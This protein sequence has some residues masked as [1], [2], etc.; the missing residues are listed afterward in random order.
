MG[1]PKYNTPAWCGK[2]DQNQRG[3][4]K[5]SDAKLAKSPKGQRLIRACRQRLIVNHKKVQESNEIL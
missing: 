4:Q 5:R 3:K 1:N 2:L